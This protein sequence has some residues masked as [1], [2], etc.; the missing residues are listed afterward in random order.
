M[1]FDK[2]L[3]AKPITGENLEKEVA[4]FEP[5]FLRNRCRTSLNGEWKFKFCDDFENLFIDPEF[6]ISDLDTIKVPSHIELQGFDK[7]KYVN[8]QYPWDGLENLKLGEV[9]KN[10]KVGI[11]FKDV[12]IKYNENEDYFLEFEGFESALYL[13]VNGKYVG[14]S[15]KN[16]TTSTFKINDFVKNGTNR[17]VVAVYRYSFISWFCDQDMWRFTGIHRDVNLVTRN[18]FH[19]VDIKNTSVLQENLI[20][21][22]AKFEFEFSKF[23][24]SLKLEFVLKYE[25]HVIRKRIYDVHKEIL[26]ID[27][28]VEGCHPW[29]DEEPNLY[30]VELVLRHNLIECEDITFKFGFRKIELVDGTLLLNGKRKIL[31][32]VNRHEFDCLNGRAT[33]KEEILKDLINIKNHNINA[34]RTSHYPNNNYFYEKC[35]ELGILVMDE[36]A[37]ETHGTWMH[38]NL[39][40]NQELNTLPGSFVTYKDVTV[41]RGLAMYERD[42]NHTCVISWSLGNE[43][44]AGTNLRSLYRRLKERDTSRFIHYEGCVHHKDYFDITDIHSEMYTYT[45]KIRKY[46]KKNKTTPFMLCEFAHSMGNST[47]NFDEYM[48]LTKEFTNYNGGFIWDYIDQGLLID[49]KFVYGGDNREF[50]HDNNFCANGLILADKTNTSKIT[51]VKY[52]Y[53][54][55][56]FEINKNLIKVTNKNSFVDTSL[57]DFKY[58]IYKD[59]TLITEERFRINIKPGESGIYHYKKEVY[60]EKGSRYLVRVLAFNKDGHEIAFDEDFIQG[61]F[62]KVNYAID[63][64]RE[65]KLEVYTSLNHITVENKNIQVIFNGVGINNGGLECINVEGKNYLN[66]IV[67]PTLFRATIDNEAVLYKYFNSYYLSASKYPFYNP[68]I[69]GIKVVSQTDKKVTVDVKYRMLAGISF[70][71][72]KIRYTIYNS[73]EIKVKYSYMPSLFVP[74]PPLIGLRFKLDGCYKEFEYKGLGREN[75][76]VDRYKGHKYGNYFSTSEDEYVNY[77]IPQ[78][79]GNHL[80]TKEVN[81]P[82]GDKT[83]SFIALNK[84]FSF[85]YLPYNEFEMENAERFEDLPTSKF[86]YLTIHAANKGV[87]GDNS[88]GA[89]IHKKYRLKFKKYSQTFVIRIK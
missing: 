64:K 17:I 66:G 78:E 47:G 32:G 30:T 35:T 86:N 14:Y 74:R 57:I 22:T 44:Y 60:L 7:P 41:E 77:S 87:G 31:K 16:Y 29:S 49:G 59:D 89:P 69:G 40:E 24:K 61:T 19:I 15:T 12:E 46:L 73:G 53:Q 1:N 45:H 71:S 21:G 2:S 68:L 23:D 82:I 6:D 55:L 25:D 54:P 43:S 28:D 88:W 76:Y 13:F 37:I 42:K 4:Y 75:N 51:T 67:L 52:Y 20:D 39:K 5:N 85:K 33:T 62:D 81:I 9:P 56:D 58:Q 50:P 79:C 83:L 63:K 70:K 72:F 84:S 36:A 48:A 26:S 38:L 34:I 18:Q 80:Y 8:A 11:Y 10:N 27:F 3:L 65:E